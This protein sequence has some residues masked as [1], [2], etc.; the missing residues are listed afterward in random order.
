MEILK[1]PYCNEALIYVSDGGYTS[2]YENNGY[3]MSCMCHFAWQN[4]DWKTASKQ[5]VKNDDLWKMLL[6]ELSKHQYRFFKVKGHSDN[7]YNNRC[8]QLATGEI[9][10]HQ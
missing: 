2:G 7:E 9:K 3:K 6:I 4:N 5:K 10:S 8:D 1:C